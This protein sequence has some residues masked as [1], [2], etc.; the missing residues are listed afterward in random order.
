M[1]PC[2]GNNLA[3]A[4]FVIS[5]CSHTTPRN[6]NTTGINNGCTDDLLPNGR[7]RSHG[8]DSYVCLSPT[9]R[10]G[11]RRINSTGFFN[12]AGSGH[13]IAPGSP[14]VLPDVAGCSLLCL[15]RRRLNVRIRRNSICVSGLSRFDR[16]NTYNAT[17]IVSPIN[18]VRRKSGFRIFCSR[19]RINPIAHGLC[20]RLANV[21]FNSVRTP[22]N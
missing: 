7:T 15:T 14:S 3:P 13:F 11:V 12:V 8:F 9:A 4:G 10:A 16:T 17:T 5:S 1:N 6:A 20:R 2:F 22:R 21:R 19:A 18:N